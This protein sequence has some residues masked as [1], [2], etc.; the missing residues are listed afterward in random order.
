MCVP[1][2]ILLLVNAVHVTA[3][4]LPGALHFHVHFVHR[5]SCT[6]DIQYWIQNVC[7]LGHSPPSKISS[8]FHGTHVQTLRPLA[9]F[10]D[11]ERIFE[12]LSAWFVR[13]EQNAWAFNHPSE[14]LLHWLI[15]SLSKEISTERLLMHVSG[16]NEL[17][18]P[19][20]TSICSAII[21]DHKIQ[22]VVSGC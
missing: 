10:L 3:V 4:H 6:Q 18:F 13:K 11:A 12:F 1:I 9:N 14:L 20:H 7:D 17:F 2:R 16:L 19:F 8:A 22:P 5:L 21:S 15:I